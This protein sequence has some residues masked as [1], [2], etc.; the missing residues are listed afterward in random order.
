MLR[1]EDRA[2]RL[3]MQ[4]KHVTI[5]D[6]IQTFSI[7]NLLTNYISMYRSIALFIT[8]LRCQHVY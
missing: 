4:L 5:T 3:Q 8:A 1:G 7:D 6:L 2:L